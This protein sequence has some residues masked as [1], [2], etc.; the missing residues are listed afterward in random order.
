MLSLTTLNGQKFIK[1]L[2]KVQI[3]WAE[4]IIQNYDVDHHYLD[5]LINEAQHLLLEDTLINISKQ[6]VVNITMDIVKL[7]EIHQPKFKGDLLLL[8]NK[9]DEFYEILLNGDDLSLLKWADKSNISPILIGYIL[10][11]ILRPEK[12]ALGKI[13]QPLLNDIKSWKSNCCPICNEPADIA[14]LLKENGER[15]LGCSCCQVTWRYPRLVC[16]FCEEANP[17]NLRYYFVEDAPEQQ[18]HYCES[19]GNYLKTFD[20]RFTCEKPADLML[21]NYMTAHLDVLAEQKGL[22]LKINN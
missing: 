9:Y 7:L 12:M 22:G 14:L 2:T 1:E 21:L 5:K 13:V 18:I 8:A 3:S 10:D 19:C 6:H 4:I 16:A 20:Y 17:E 15:H 11:W